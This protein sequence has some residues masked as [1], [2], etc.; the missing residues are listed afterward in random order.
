MYVKYLL[1]V[2]QNNHIPNMLITLIIL[3]VVIKEDGN[4]R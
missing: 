4:L 1:N 2:E 3:I